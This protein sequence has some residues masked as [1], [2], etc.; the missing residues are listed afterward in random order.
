MALSFALT[1]LSV[2][3]A[4]AVILMRDRWQRVSATDP[5]KLLAREIAGTFLSYRGTR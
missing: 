5:R 2:V 4:S 3:C 1:G